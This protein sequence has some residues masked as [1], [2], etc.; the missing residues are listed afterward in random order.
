M[1]DSGHPD[2]GGLLRMLRLARGYS[3]RSLARLAGLDS[4]YISRL[5][6]GAYHPPKVPT[7]HRLAQA[8]DLNS[9]DEAALIEASGRLPDSMRVIARSDLSGTDGRRTRGSQATG[10]SSGGRRPTRE[11]REDLS[12]RIDLEVHAFRQI[13]DAIGAVFPGEA[14]REVVTA[15]LTARGYEAEPSFGGLDFIATR[16]RGGGSSP[17][18]YVFMRTERKADLATLQNF[19]RAADLCH[20]ELGM[21]VCWDG[22]TPNAASEARRVSWITLLDADGTTQAFLD[23]YEQLPEEMRARIPLK[24]VWVPAP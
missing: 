1:Q 7:V 17:P 23:E 15:I 3:Q 4:T 16:R 6:S 19:R 5:E 22:F 24:K 10:R 9:D 11:R 12:G 14:L 13:R 21:L 20:A 8:L 18:M 2:F